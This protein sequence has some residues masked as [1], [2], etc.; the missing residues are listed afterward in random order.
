MRGHC[1]LQAQGFPSDKKPE[2]PPGTVLS[3]SLWEGATLWTPPLQAASP[4][5]GD[6]HVVEA[7]LPEHLAAAALGS[8]RRESRCSA[9]SLERL[10]PNQ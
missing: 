6:P 9:H 5:T 3:H 1:C 10:S 4:R 7:T 2:E 8:L